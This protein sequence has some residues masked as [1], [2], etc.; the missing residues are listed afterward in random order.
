MDVAYASSSGTSGWSAIVVTG[1]NSRPFDNRRIAA[2]RECAVT[3]SSGVFLVRERDVRA[4]R[5]MSSPTSMPG[6][7]KRLATFM[8]TGAE[9]DVSEMAAQ[10]TSATMVG[11]MPIFG[12][13]DCIKLM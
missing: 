5:L 4:Y 7:V 9:A 10:R 1:D 8:R 13:E 12:R 6:V 3:E 2:S 11:T